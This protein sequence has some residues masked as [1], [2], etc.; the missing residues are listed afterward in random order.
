MTYT[1]YNFYKYS[2]LYV[3]IIIA[4][5]FKTIDLYTYFHFA[6]SIRSYRKTYYIFIKSISIKDLALDFDLF[7]LKLYKLR[8]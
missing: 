6:Y 3:Y 5:R 1:C 8:G 2:G 7:L 4:Y